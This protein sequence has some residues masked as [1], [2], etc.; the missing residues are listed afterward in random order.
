[1]S[2]AGRPILHAAM[3]SNIADLKRRF[4]EAKPFRHVL[5]EN[6]FAADVVSDLIRQFPVPDPT[7]MINEFGH[8]SKKFAR[9]DVRNIGPVYAELD[10]YIRS[11]KFAAL[12]SELTG[13]PG[14]L[15]D[16]E[17]HGAGTHDNHDGQGMD[18]HVDFNLHRSTGYHRRINAIIYLNESWDP[19]WGGKSRTAQEPVGS[20]SRRG[21][22]LSAIQEPLRAVRDKRVFLAR[23]SCSQRPR[24]QG[25]LAAN[26]SRSTC[27]QKKDR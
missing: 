17:Y 10:D 11:P 25:D 16:P 4:A 14:L 24:R 21:H 9:H 1:M 26:R 23:L 15:Y 6:F 12:M 22:R 19:K 8:G 18:P 20:R 2:E 7:K 5:I 13:I 3:T 27:T